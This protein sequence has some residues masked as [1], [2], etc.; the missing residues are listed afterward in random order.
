MALHLRL[1][2]HRSWHYH[3]PRPSLLYVLVVS[4]LLCWLGIFLTSDVTQLDPVCNGDQGLEGGETGG[5]TLVLEC[6]HLCYLCDGDQI[7]DPKTIASCTD[8][9]RRLYDF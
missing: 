4:Q 3:P 9:R 5:N 1:L 2:H 7:S 6:A 8:W